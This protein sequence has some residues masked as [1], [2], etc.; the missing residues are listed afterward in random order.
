MFKIKS[1]S[2]LG[3][4]PVFIRPQTE[5]T[6]IDVKSLASQ[7][8]PSGT[9]V[10]AGIQ[11][12]GRGRFEDRKWITG[13]ESLCFSVL[14]HINDFPPLTSA[15]PL[16]IGLALT[17]AIE[18]TFGLKPQIKWPNDVLLKGRK[19]AGILVEN[20]EEHIFIGMG[21]NCGSRSYPKELKKT[22]ISL[23][24]AGAKCKPED[25]LFP[26]LEQMKAWIFERDNWREEILKRL[27]AKGK[28]VTF[29]PGLSDGTG[30]FEALLEGIE[31]D[32][33][34]LLR[35]EGQPEAVAYANG[36]L[37]YNPPKK[38]LFSMRKKQ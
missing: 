17:F 4:V 3:E 2:P 11:T 37:R 33:R 13:P 9:V 5:S 16:R 38:P 15:I 1:A 30:A 7:G 29:L 23:K 22:A 31:E 28:M 26:V 25:F 21:I 12:A 35:Q 32:G 14:F 36:E 6:M 20:R 8:M 34:L 27:Y 19:V 10:M 24:E 18:K